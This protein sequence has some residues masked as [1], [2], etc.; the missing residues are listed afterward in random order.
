MKYFPE[1]MKA[2]R[3]LNGYSLQDLSDKLSISLS[4]QALSRL[5]TGEVK[6][7]SKT[8]SILSKVL[9]VG[10]DY[11]FRQHSV[12]L[13]DI[14][15]RKLKSL[16]AKELDK[17]TAQTVDFLERYLELEDIL[18]VDSPLNFSLKLKKVETFGEVEKAAEELREKWKLGT[19]P[20][21][22]IIEMLEEN[23]IKVF[24]ID[25]DTSFSG[26]STIVKNKIPVIVLNISQSIPQT[27][28]RFTALHELAHLYL[29][30]DH[31]D[32][33]I[34]EKF[35]DVF[36]GAFLLPGKKLEAFLGN[37]RSKIL[38]NELIMIASQYGISMAAIMYRAF[39]L[40]IISASYHKFFMIR[41]NK[42]HI[43][44]KEFEVYKGREK[45]D[46]F[47]QLI[48]RAVAEEVISTSKAASLNNQKLG[49]FREILD[50]K[51]LLQ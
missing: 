12:S 10:A 45:S 20:L 23:G 36:A 51:W 8:I 30:L 33:K 43:K 25:A 17:I 28:I 24:I 49:D 18:G 15:F 37:K 4:K 39:S 2:A 46:R 34:Y 11:F 7:D 26:M 22:N 19:D 50:E 6:P 40:E 48:F 13:D 38:T 29:K 35:C 14:K 47:L 31:L 32:E 21:P 3:K 1:R 27:R 16:P 9:N 5:E 44:E 41:Y 42:F